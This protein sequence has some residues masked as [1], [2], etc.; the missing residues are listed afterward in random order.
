MACWSP[1]CGKKIMSTFQNFICWSF[2]ALRY[3]W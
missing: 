3:W 2:E 1:T